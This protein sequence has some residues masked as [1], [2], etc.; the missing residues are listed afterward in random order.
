MIFYFPSVGGLKNT[1]SAVFMV[2]IFYLGDSLKSFLEI[3]LSGSFSFIW[4]VVGRAGDYERQSF[5]FSII[6]MG[7][8]DL[9]CTSAGLYERARCGRS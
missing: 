2:K 9:L 3:G 4:P 5:P 8:K 7:D 1:T 6:L